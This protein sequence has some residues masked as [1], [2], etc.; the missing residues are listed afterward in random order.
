MIHLGV[1]GR[2]LV[3]DR[4]TGI[5]RY[6]RE[7]VRAMAARG[8]RCTVYGDGRTAFDD[9]LPRVTLARLSAPATPWW[10]QIALPRALVRDD[11]QVFLSPYY[12]GPIVAPCPVVLTIHDLDFIGYGG[13]RGLRDVALTAAARLYA[14]RASAIVADSEYARQ[15]AVARLGVDADRVAVTGVAVGVEFVPT[16]L[17]VATRARYDLGSSYVLFVGNFMPHKNV[18]ALLRAWAALPARLRTIHRLVLAGTDTARRPR[19]QALA[20]EL[21]LTASVVFPGGIDDADLPAVYSACTA[22]VLPSLH[23]GFGL[24]AVEAMA[25]G[26]P[27]VVSDRGALPEVAGP[28]AAVVDVQ[29]PGALSALLARLLVKPEPR[30]A[31]RRRGRARAADFAPAR[32]AGRVVDLLEAVAD[33]P[34]VVVR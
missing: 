12:K 19:L 10:D 28:G 34:A 31:L 17:P 23:E 2:E 1:D 15:D 27:V 29:A 24:P 9:A 14:R 25:C 22:F 26:A 11:V 21:D 33:V 13:R 4:R 8:W 5:G 7:V 6:V 18:A 30:D 32:T 20:R 16:P 3:A